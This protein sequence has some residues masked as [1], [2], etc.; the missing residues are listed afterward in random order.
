MTIINPQNKVLKL[1]HTLANE[2]DNIM[3]FIKGIMS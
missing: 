2:K 1:S 3:I